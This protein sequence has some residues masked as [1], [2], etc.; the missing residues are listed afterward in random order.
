[1]SLL[2]FFPTLLFFAARVL[3]IKTPADIVFLVSFMLVMVLELFREDRRVCRFLYSACCV[4]MCLFCLTL[5]SLNT[6]FDVS[7]LVTCVIWLVLLFSP[8]LDNDP[9][10]SAKK[11]V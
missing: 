8:I 3:L 5:V 11:T 7:F 4:C 2:L 1:M 6:I 9:C 10:L